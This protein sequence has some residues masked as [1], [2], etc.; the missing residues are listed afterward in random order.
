MFNLIVE[1]STSVLVIAIISA[2]LIY[3]TKHYTF[4]DN[5]YAKFVANVENNDFSLSQIDDQAFK[6]DNYLWTVVASQYILTDEFMD[7]YSDKLDITLL[8]IHQNFTSSKLIT[9]IKL[10]ENDYNILDVI[11]LYQTCKPHVQAPL[12]IAI[13]KH[14]A[15][16]V[17][18]VYFFDH[19]DNYADNN[20]ALALLRNQG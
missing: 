11:N 16:S 9:L 8:L 7:K 15:Y 4:D 12:H 6:L 14:A 1:V 2:Y 19:A 17:N 3:L 18:N 10:Y 13:S 5:G 20:T